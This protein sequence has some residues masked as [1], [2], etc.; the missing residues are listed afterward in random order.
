[1][2]TRLA[3]A[4][5]GVC[6]ALSTSAPA[7]GFRLPR[8]AIPP[9]TPTE[10]RKHIEGLYSPE[11]RDRATAVEGLRKLG[12]RAVAA[13][14]LLK[15][16][17][18]DEARVPMQTTYT[19][20]CQVTFGK[21]TIGRLAA[22]ALWAIRPDDFYPLLSDKDARRRRCAVESVAEGGTGT[23]VVKFL[24]YAMKDR[25]VPIRRAAAWGLHRHPGRL[26]MKTLV[27]ATA[28]RSPEVRAAAVRAL[29]YMKRL[30]EWPE[31]VPP[32]IRVLESDASGTCR[33]GAAWALGQLKARRAVPALTKALRDPDK[34]VRSRASEALRWLVGSKEWK[35]LTAS[36]KGAGAAARVAAKSGGAG[37]KPAGTVQLSQFRL[38]G[39]V[40]GPS[41]PSAILNGRLVRTGDTVGGAKI[42][43]IGPREVELEKDSRRFV[44]RR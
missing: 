18:L 41:G 37:R 33:A 31:A 22:D 20:S 25:D 15:G 16:L 36:A 32:L 17:L 26:V 24:L 6:L 23:E 11:A 8:R 27:Q 14:P 29:G 12:P 9:G 4:A 1:M 7:A 21:P 19:K 35:R 28:D 44:V 42:V 2:I 30:R 13:V 40:N 3:A 38:G 34:S 5:C 10:V 43:R 39:I